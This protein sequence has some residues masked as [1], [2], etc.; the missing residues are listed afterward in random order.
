MM[1]SPSNFRLLFV[2]GLRLLS[3]VD[4]FKV[5]ALVAY[6][7]WKSGKLLSWSAST[8]LLVLVGAIEYV[9]FNKTRGL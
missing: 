8:P 7:A 4:R 2:Q 9:R 3:A 1:I 6:L 5:R